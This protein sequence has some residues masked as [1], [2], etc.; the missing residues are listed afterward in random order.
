MTDTHTLK[1]EKVCHVD[2]T[3]CDYQHQHHEY[4][5]I[6]DGNKLDIIKSKG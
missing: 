5:P 4:I 6:I 3:E 1:T 2:G